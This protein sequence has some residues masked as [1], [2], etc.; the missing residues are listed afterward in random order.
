MLDDIIYLGE[1]FNDAKKEDENN[2]A[3]I[4]NV[5]LDEFEIEEYE[6]ETIEDKAR[7]ALTF[8]FIGIG[9]CGGKIVQEFY[10]LGY[11]KCF[12]INT[13]LQDMDKIIIPNKMFMQ[14]EGF[15]NGA[16]KDMEIARQIID[17]DKDGI[18]NKMR[19]LFG[20]VDH[21]FICAGLGGGTGGG[22]ITTVIEMAKKYM[23][24]INVPFAEKK[25]GVIATLPTLGETSSPLVAGNAYEK[26]NELSTLAD[27]EEITPFIIIDNEKVKSLYK[28]LTVAKFFPT[29]NR[30]IAQLLN[31]FNSIALESS[32]F[33]NFDTTDFQS[34]L[35]VGGHMVMGTSTVRDFSSTTSISEALKKN[36]SK[37]LLASNFDLSRA[38]AVACIVV[39]G[40]QEFETIEGLMEN[41]NF[42][43]DTIAAFTGNAKVHRGIYSDVNRNGRIN[44]YTMIS[45][46]EKP[47]ARYEKMKPANYKKGKKK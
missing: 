34:I 14:L 15:K 12:I 32:E 41:I 33:I 1:K 24:Y 36:L 43:F 38:K 40:E 10:N 22:G 44:V 26:G 7:G 2:M 27:M 11:T 6:D 29:I 17:A 3:P 30:S 19:E 5:D 47:T 16:G 23:T 42:G 46:L 35:E 13:A 25:V 39:G 9:Q 31:V 45:G 18:Y 21:I 37:T 4:D 20:T 8:A 28:K